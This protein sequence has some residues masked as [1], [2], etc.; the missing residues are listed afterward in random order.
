MGP[1]HDQVLFGFSSGRQKSESARAIK[2]CYLYSY[3]RLIMDTLLV[4]IGIKNTL[5]VSHSWVFFHCGTPNLSVQ[6]NAGTDVQPEHVI[7]KTRVHRPVSA[8]EAFCDR[9]ST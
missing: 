9:G 2:R 8:S 6:E 3:K 5:T 7:G 4:S 1:Q